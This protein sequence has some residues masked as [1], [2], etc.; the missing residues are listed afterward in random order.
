M[1]EKETSQNEL[2]EVEKSDNNVGIDFDELKKLIISLFRMKSSDMMYRELFSYLDTAKKVQDS[3]NT[4]DKG[5]D[6]EELDNFDGESDN[7]DEESDNG[8]D[9]EELDAKYPPDVR[10]QMRMTHSVDGLIGIEFHYLLT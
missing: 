9:D 1:V 6:N 7:Y 2:L 5:W 10:Y 3:K 4:T 8:L